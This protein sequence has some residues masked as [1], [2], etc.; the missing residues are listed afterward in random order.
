MPGCENN[1][2]SDFDRYKDFIFDLKHGRW[3]SATEFLISEPEAVR[4][5]I[6]PE[7]DT[8]LHVAVKRA[9]LQV[10][11]E[12][13]QRM[14][15]EDL[16]IKDDYGC[17]AFAYAMVIG[18]IEMAKC[19][20]G[21]NKKLVSIRAPPNNAIP[22]INAYR[23]G[24]WEMVD[25]LYSLTPFEDL[26]DRDGAA[27]ICQCFLSKHFGESFTYIV[28]LMLRTLICALNLLILGWNSRI[29][30]SLLR[31][32]CIYIYSITVL[33]NLFV[34]NNKFFS[35][36]NSYMYIDIGWDLIRRRPT[37]A[38]TIDYSGQYPLNALFCMPYVFPT[39]GRLNLWQRRIYHC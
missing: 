32:N 28:Y 39:R 30:R 10:V 8:A 35:T 38:T 5:R 23:R 11:K 4:S 21:K 16:E 13:V 17:T 37:L 1:A 9:R 24:Q 6:T 29:Y 31:E 14:R 26:D 27:L 34:Y 20:V 36:S 3:D 22:L 12:L 19:L 15:E 7:G 25:Y 2:S 18:K 33:I